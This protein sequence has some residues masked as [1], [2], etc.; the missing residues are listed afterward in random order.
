MDYTH[1]GCYAAYTPTCAAGSSYDSAIGQCISTPACGHGL[2]DTAANVCYENITLSCGTLSLDGGSG[3]CYSPPVC[4]PG[5]YVATDKACEIAPGNGCGSYSWDATANVCA[6]AVSCP[7]DPT[8]SLNSTVAFSSTAAECVSDALHTCATGTT[9]TGLPVELCQAVPICAPG[10]TYNSQTNTCVSSYNCP[11]SPANCHQLAGDTTMIAPGIPAQYCSANKCQ[12]D[13]SGWTSVYDTTSGQN[14]KANDGAHDANGNCLGQIYLFNGTDMRCREYDLNGMVD[15]FAKVAGAIALVCTGLGASLTGY[16]VGAGYITAA[17]SAAGILTTALANTA[18][19]LALNASLDAATGQASSISL[20]SAATTLVAQGLLEWIQLPPPTAAVTGLIDGVSV[21]VEMN[22]AGDLISHAVNS[23]ATQVVNSG[24]LFQPIGTLTLAASNMAASSGFQAYMQ[25][26]GQMVDTFSPAISQGM[27]GAYT[28]T[29]CCYPD[30]LSAGCEST[31]RQEATEQ[32]NN[33]CHIVGSYCSS[34]FLFACMVKKQT[35]CCFQS[36]L[37]RI[38]H[39]QGRAQLQSFSSGW[40]TPSSPN[41]RGFTPEE[42]QALNFSIM[43]LSEWQASLS[44]NMNQIQ[45][46]V[47][48]FVGSTGTAATQAIQN[49]P[50]NTTNK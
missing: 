18:A 15:S 47:Q 42:F 31:E 4:T 14:D 22:A 49:S 9:Y 3:V 16:L 23:V 33:M 29:K 43:D 8:Y 30:K 48:S 36:Q 6:Q 20:I 1:P 11:T 25:G 2:L 17:S 35:S 24:A 27:L 46:A 45:A 44:A 13:T 21:S 50:A 37:A 5:A 28:P 26:I 12:S 19:I 39:E 38:M 10:A 40:G 34:T 41:C 7:T 32:H